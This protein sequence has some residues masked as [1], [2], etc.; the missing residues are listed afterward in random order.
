MCGKY[1]SYIYTHTHIHTCVHTH[2]TQIR[3]AE[4]ECES[5]RKRLQASQR[6]IT[7]LQRN[8]HV[9]IPTSALLQD[10]TQIY[11]NNNTSTMS[12]SQRSYTHR[13][14]SQNAGWGQ[15]WSDSTHVSH[16]QSRAATPQ[17]LDDA[18]HQAVDQRV[19]PKT[20]TAKQHSLHAAT[21]PSS[22]AQAP[23]APMCSDTGSPKTTG[24]KSVGVDACVQTLLSM[25]TG[26]LCTSADVARLQLKVCAG[27][28]QTS[29]VKSR[30]HES[31]R[32]ADVRAAGVHRTKTEESR[33]GDSVRVGE[34]HGPNDDDDDDDGDAGSGD[35]A[36]ENKDENA[37]ANST[38]GHVQGDE[39][40]ENE[41]M[42]AHVHVHEAQKETLHETTTEP[43]SESVSD[44]HGQG[45]AGEENNVHSSRGEDEEQSG[46]DLGDVGRDSILEESC[47]QTAEDDVDDQA[48]HADEKQRSGQGT[49][50]GGP[51]CRDHDDSYSEH[52]AVS[53]VNGHGDED[54]GAGGVDM[55]GGEAH[56]AIP[57]AG[58]HIGTD[59]HAS[60][61]GKKIVAEAGN[62]KEEAWPS[63]RREGTGEA[64]AR[65]PNAD[66]KGGGGSMD[67]FMKEI[68]RFVPCLRMLLLI[69][70]FMHECQF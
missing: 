25:L 21:G 41:H 59:G 57:H 36:K 52:L 9:Q 4:L 2:T 67:L 33:E 58:A 20:G 11:T 46:V 15:H 18:S 35:D 70:A 61:R 24:N 47:E 27:A 10:G 68:Y 38:E 66:E 26:S 54:A 8:Q 3:R 39:E 22:S 48:S 50:G 56:D 45:L 43:V 29:W 53:E 23:L 19:T 60:R 55:Q 1:T 42:H 34:R 12:E 17:L 16:T 69:T 14:E 65:T 62:Q 63:R 31:V 7:E 44:T 37:Q 28:D 40:A 64:R 49:Q 5:L 13:D 30:L 51:E 32:R 6:L